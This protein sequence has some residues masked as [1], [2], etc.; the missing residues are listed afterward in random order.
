VIAAVS[1][2]HSGLSR[3]GHHIDNTDRFCRRRGPDHAWTRIQPEPVGG[4]V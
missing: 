4:Q 3:E 2:A 1:G